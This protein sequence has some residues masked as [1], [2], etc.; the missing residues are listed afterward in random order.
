MTCANEFATVDLLLD[1]K[2][3]TRGVDA[4]AL[5]LIKT[6]RQMRR[7]VTYLV[8][9]FPC[10]HQGNTDRLRDVLHQKKVYF[11]GLEWGFDAL[12]PKSVRA[13]IGSEYDILRGRLREAGNHRNK[14]FHGQLTA[15]YLSRQEL[16]GYIC[17]IRRW[18]AAL[19][20]AALAEFDYDG[21]GR[22][23]FRKSKTPNLWERFKVQ[24]V[25]VADYEKFISEKMERR[26]G[27]CQPKT[28]DPT[29]QEK[30]KKTE[31]IMTRYGTTLEVLAK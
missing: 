5:A 6:E 17:D 4:F 31:G 16:L 15:E 14:I 28:G 2:H 27:R 29:F 7:L 20:N 25:S 13:L 21:F 3:E 18:C 9:Q 24:I 19:S 23:S 10:F 26:R 11:D 8:Y 1:S 12:Y 22:N 30:M